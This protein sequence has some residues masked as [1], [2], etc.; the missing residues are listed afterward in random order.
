MA[1]PLGSSVWPGGGHPSLAFPPLEAV[2]HSPGG[3][4]GSAH[5]PITALDF[6][7]VNDARVVPMYR[8]SMPASFFEPHHDQATRGRPRQAQMEHWQYHA[9]LS[10]PGESVLLPLPHGWHHAITAAGDRYYAK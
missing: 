4:L 2:R 6:L 7:F 9:F 10:T 8:R 5:P 3:S 1:S